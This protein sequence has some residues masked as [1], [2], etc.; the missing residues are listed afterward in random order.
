MS[1][2]AGDTLLIQAAQRLKDSVRIDD[3]V[4]RLGGDEFI[5]LLG[6]L[7]TEQDV[8][9]VAEKILNGFKTP[10]ILDGREFILTSSI[11]ISLYPSDG[12][13]PAE[14]LRNADT[15]MYQ[16]KAQGRN[17]LSFF[18]YEMN[19]GIS[20]RL[21][22]E[23]Q[24]HGA[25]ERNEFQLYY[26]PILDIAK[27]E[28]IGAESLLRWNNPIL[29]NVS[30]DEFIPITEQTGQI[31][32]LGQ[33]VIEQALCMTSQWQKQFEKPFKV[34]INISPRQFRDPNLI[35]QIKSVLNQCKIA[36]RSVVLEITE[37]VLMS[38]HTYIDNAL[39]ELNKLG[40]TI[41]MDDFGTGYSSLSYLRR[42]PFG[43]LKIDRSFIK[44]VTTDPA[45]KELVN[46]AIA[47]AHGLG[48][49]VVAEG[50]E[51]EDQLDYLE[52][53]GCDMAQGFLFSK[54]V[55]VEEMER[56]LSTQQT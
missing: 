54:P 49:T 1:H 34:A 8:L 44:D 50:V 29:G 21:K 52:Q 51:T 32:P 48:I 25:L 26:Q 16:S 39:T 14:L 15:A 33:F 3:T 17:T 9:P 35:K 47:M 4:S 10:F 20:R 18:T 43:N 6:N 30:P 23:E 11:G 13:S 12:K 24:L 2:E 53:L 27:R 46:A 40:M 28:I 42:Y 38:G 31:V 22:V 37:G 45:D 5:V 7:Q 55:P 19:Q 41:T 56:M 36:S